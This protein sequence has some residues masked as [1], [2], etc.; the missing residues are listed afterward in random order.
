MMLSQ[1]ICSCAWNG[2]ILVLPWNAKLYLKWKFLSM[3]S[4]FVLRFIGE[5]ERA[6][7]FFHPIHQNSIERK[8]LR[9]T[10]NPQLALGGTCT[11]KVPSVSFLF[12]AIVYWLGFRFSFDF[13][14]S[15]LF[16]SSF[17]LFLYY[18]FSASSMKSFYLRPRATRYLMVC[19]EYFWAGVRC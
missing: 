7:S 2:A 17:F 3:D 11:V 9:A 13:F 14:L 16:F 8:L 6:Y 12:T 4:N 5:N 10:T 15:C 19:F 18:N 1:H